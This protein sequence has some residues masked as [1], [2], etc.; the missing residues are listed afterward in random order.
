MVA[1]VIESPLIPGDLGEYLPNDPESG[2]AGIP[3]PLCIDC[4]PEIVLPLR[5]GVQLFLCESH[6]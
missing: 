3:C 1:V 2:L 4:S 6:D 5:E